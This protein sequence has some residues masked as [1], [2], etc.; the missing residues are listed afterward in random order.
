MSLI[1]RNI[2]G[3][4]IEADDIGVHIESAEDYDITDTSPVDIAASNDIVDLIQNGFLIVLDPL[5]DATP[6]T[7]DQS[8]ECIRSA[9]DTHYRIRGAELNQL[10]DVDVTSPTDG[11]VLTFDNND[12]TW[13]PQP[14]GGAGSGE[15]NTASNLGAGAGWFAQKV[16]VDLQFKSITAGTGI[17]VTPSATEIDVAVTNPSPTGL[18]VTTINGQEIL[19]LVDITRTNKIL[20][21][22]TTVIT[23]S[24]NAIKKN[25]WMAIGSASNAINGY[26]PMLNATIVGI[27]GQ[28]RNGN[29]KALD[30]Y[31]DNVNTMQVAIFPT[32][33]DSRFVVSDLNIDINQGQKISL[34]GSA[35]GG[36]T[37]EASASLILRWRG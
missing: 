18:T 1:V 7:I 33:I 5:D 27:T 32:A 30:L 25:T 2:S 19:T 11:Y 10:D 23:F 15:A 14:S 3:T 29:G 26:L 20:S 21:T 4:P 12:S 13:K 34:R 8:I 17:T 36:N 37:N 6:L 16:A 35:V 22:D 24:K 28:A 31:I 9:N